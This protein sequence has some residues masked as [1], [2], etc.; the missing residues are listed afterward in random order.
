MDN[1]TLF[2]KLLMFQL[3]FLKKQLMFMSV[4]TNKYDSIEY[5][6][7]PYIKKQKM[8]TVYVIFYSLAVVPS[9]VVG[10]YLRRVETPIYPVYN[11]ILVIVLTGIISILVASIICLTYLYLTHKTKE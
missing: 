6:K 1:K 3:I 2:K 8:R 5:E 11:V 10:T 9:V 7:H 4:F